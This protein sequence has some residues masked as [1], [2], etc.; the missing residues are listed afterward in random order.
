MKICIAMDSFKESMT[1]IKAC[2]A[3]EK[4]INEIDKNIES[5]KVPMADGGEGTVE[6]LVDG[7]DGRRIYE[8]VTGPLFNEV[9]GSYGI[10]GDGETAIIEMAEVSGLTLVD[11]KD[12]NPMLTTTYGTGQLIL[13]AMD[14]GVKNIILAIGGSATND[15]G[16]GMA[17]ALG[18]KFLDKNKEQIKPCGGQ[19]DKIDSIDMDGLDK[20]I[21]DIKITIACDVDNPFTGK[22]GASEIFGRQ[23]GATDEDVKKLDNNLKHLAKKIK[24]YL[25]KDIENIKGAGA[26]GGLGGGCLAFINGELKP[27]VDI[28]IKITDLENKIKNSNIVITGEGQTDGQT[29]HGKTAFGVAKVAKKY[30]KKVIC[31]SGSLG[32]GYEEMFNHNID[33]MF[34][35]IKKLD[36]LDNLLLSGEDNLTKTTKEIIKLLKIK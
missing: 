23:K 29:I 17:N 10:L 6:A 15:G 8:T 36:T 13:S 11:I 12:R 16:V 31:I 9:K 21:K 19:L 28:V 34:P 7:T 26:A 30:N 27:G 5:I 1:A 22:Y 14:Q 32:D 20:R 24:E 18:V 35:I 33:I 3:V 2:S 25:N 4:G